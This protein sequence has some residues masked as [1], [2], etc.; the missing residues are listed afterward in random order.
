MSR[1]GTSRGGRGGGDG[2]KEKQ[3]L[4]R[5]YITTSVSCALDEMGARVLVTR[6]ENVA[7][8]LHMS[9]TGGYPPRYLFMNDPTQGICLSA[10]RPRFCS[11]VALLVRLS[12]GF[13]SSDTPTT[14]TRPSFLP[15]CCFEQTAKHKRYSVGLDDAAAVEL[16]SATGGDASALEAHGARKAAR[17]REGTGVNSALQKLEKV[18]F[19]ID[20]AR[21]HRN[22]SLRFE[23]CGENRSRFTVVVLIKVGV[24]TSR[25]A[26]E[27]SRRPF[28]DGCYP[29]KN[30]VTS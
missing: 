18:H 17:E 27:S 3:K 25:P 1:G 16:M 23:T 7:R 10:C 15:P 24:C 21:V 30:A 9:V 28:R 14:P 4:V 20:R 22:T 19:L 12:A 6:S 8:T 29:R 13:R 26:A 11:F 2:G 5:A